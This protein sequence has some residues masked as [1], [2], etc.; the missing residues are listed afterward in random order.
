[1]KILKIT[2]IITLFCSCS[3]NKFYVSKIVDGNSI[4]L[5]N[6]V[7]ITLLEVEKRKENIEDLEKYLNKKVLIY[8]KSNERIT[9]FDSDNLGAF[10]FD[11]NGECLNKNLQNKSFSS[12]NKVSKI[13][14]EFL[15]YDSVRGKVISILDGDT[16]DMLINE[17]Q[18]IRVRMEG[19]DAPERGMP[20]Y[21]VSKKYL[22]NLC[23]GQMVKLK[24]T[25]KES[26]GRVLAFSFLDDGRELSH[27]MLK[28]G[29]A[30]HYIKYNSDLDLATLEMKA[31]NDK[32]GLWIDNDPM[33]PWDNKALHYKGI[34]TK[35]SFDIKVG[36]E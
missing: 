10:V 14:N 29:L 2:I 20:F 23:N 11:Y 36:Q 24:V 35:D 7:I 6:G 16:Y 4:E 9:Q 34:S 32:L 13:G 21:K 22:G 17:N 33:P 30:W 28:A 31:R 15:D 5:N 18:T 1:M 3:S 27:E 26:E 25:K 19:I 8:N 12:E